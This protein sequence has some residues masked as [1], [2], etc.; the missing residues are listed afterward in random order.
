MRDTLDVVQAVD[1]DNQ[2][3]AL[4]F[5]LERC[6]A[7]LNLGFLKAFVELLRVDSNREGTYGDDLTLKL[8]A[9]RCCCE[10]TDLVSE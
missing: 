8:N 10:A 7:L 1:T 2:L 9:I 6:D 3:D 4:E 5:L